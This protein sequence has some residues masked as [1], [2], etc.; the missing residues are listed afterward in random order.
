MREISMKKTKIEL[1]LRVGDIDLRESQ[2][3]YNDP[4]TID[5]YAGIFGDLC[6]ELLYCRC[7]FFD[8]EKKKEQ[9]EKIDWMIKRLKDRKK[10][11]EQGNYLY[12]GGKIG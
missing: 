12:P 5:Y 2:D 3:I 7:I 10:Q 4:K 1:I 9:I 11:I 8:K 6:A